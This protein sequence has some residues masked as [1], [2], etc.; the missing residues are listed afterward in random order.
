ML[1]PSK[2]IRQD[3]QTARRY[4]LFFVDNS[5]HSLYK[6]IDCYTFDSV[7]KTITNLYSIHCLLNHGRNVASS[8]MRI[9][10]LSLNGR[11]T[12]KAPTL[13][14]YTVIVCT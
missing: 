3:K 10:F 2:I 6:C 11:K 9:C 12:F 5:S 8:K 4:I 14:T 1:S 7:Q 13:F